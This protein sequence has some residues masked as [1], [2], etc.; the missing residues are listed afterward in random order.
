LIRFAYL[1]EPPFCFKDEAGL[2]T[3][4]DVELARVIA[5]RLGRTITFVEAEFADL[6]PGLTED[7]WD[8]TT[9]LFVTEPRRRIAAFSRPIWTLADGLLV[10]HGNPLRLTGYRSV[11]TTRARLAIV[12]DQ[13]QERHARGA[14]VPPEMIAIHLTYEQ[15]ARAVIEGHAD[16]YASVA[17]A[18]VAFVA[19]RPSQ[20]EVVE[21]PAA[22]QAPGPGAFGLRLQDR[23]LLSD[24][25]H[26]LS[27]FLGSEAH[28]E[29]MERFGLRREE[30]APLPA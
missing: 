27:D 4:C 16:A 10:A 28:A 24:V 19:A 30:Y 1:V 6:L 12:Q 8:L 3:G 25:N 5:A 9:G 21:I 2:P 15:A 11:A 29:L 20:A 17:R 18:H 23:A 22:E 13:V 14:G 7:R 26:A